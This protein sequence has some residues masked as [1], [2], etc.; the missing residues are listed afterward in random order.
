MESALRDGGG[1][2]GL[3]LIE[4]MLWTG[5]AAPRWPLHLARL[6]RSAAAL[7]WPVPQVPPPPAP[8]HPARL[9]LT[10]DARGAALWETHPL[11][12]AAPQWVL[13]LAPARLSSADPWL[14][15]K[16]TRRALYDQARA[17][18]HPA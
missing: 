18:R 2:P 11:P 16:T 10:L 8:P 1:A 9:R 7:G 15:H 14:R 17:A 12:P 3:R 5:A 4:T 13:A 6:H